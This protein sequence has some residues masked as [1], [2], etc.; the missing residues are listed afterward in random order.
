MAREL[1]LERFEKGDIEEAVAISCCLSVYKMFKDFIENT[2]AK[3]A[4][5]LMDDLCKF[6]EDYNSLFK[7]E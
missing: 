7:K 1:D 6:T 4:T 5:R 2:D 3:D